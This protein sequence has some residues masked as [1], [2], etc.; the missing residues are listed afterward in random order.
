MYQLAQEAVAD[1]AQW[2]T[3]WWGTPVNLLDDDSEGSTTSVQEKKGHLL[4]N[5]RQT[6]QR[7]KTLNYLFHLPYLNHLL[8]LDAHL[9]CKKAR[10]PWEAHCRDQLERSHN[11]NLQL[12]PK[13]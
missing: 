10:R 6:R 2:S 8:Y 9:Y 5:R 4:N 1:L 7:R 12:Y 3:Q 11:Y 13:T